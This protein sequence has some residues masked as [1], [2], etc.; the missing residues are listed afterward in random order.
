MTVA[1]WSLW[2]RA[3][4]IGIWSLPGTE[5]IAAGS[6]RCGSEMRDEIPPLLCGEDDGRR[7]RYESLKP[8][9]QRRLSAHELTIKSSTAI[10]SSTI[11]DYQYDGRQQQN[12]SHVLLRG[13]GSHNGTC[14]VCTSSCRMCS[15]GVGGAEALVDSLHST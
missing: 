4:T 1:P 10:A 2:W 14:S 11:D 9:S 8:S 3:A 15:S 5:A 13:G 7:W 6:S 12:K